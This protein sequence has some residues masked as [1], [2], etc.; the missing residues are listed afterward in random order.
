MKEFNEIQLLN[1]WLKNLIERAIKIDVEKGEF[2]QGLQQGYYE[3]ISHLLNQ[4]EGHN[5]MDK[6]AD[7]YLKNFNAE[8]IING[9]AKNPF[10]IKK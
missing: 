4:I 9:T 2:Y 10:E 5:L 3:T 6:F 7:K 8:D 1:D